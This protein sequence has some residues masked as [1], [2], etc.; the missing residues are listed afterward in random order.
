M[1]SRPDTP[2]DDHEPGD[3]VLAILRVVT[4]SLGAPL[5]FIALLF[6]VTGT[7]GETLALGAIAA[8]V[9]AVAA[10]PHPRPASDVPPARAGQHGG[11]TRPAPER[12]A[13]G[14]RRPG[15]ALD[16]GGRQEACPSRHERPDLGADRRGA[17]PD[18]CGGPH[19]PAR[20][21]QPAGPPAAGG[22]RRVVTRFPSPEAPFHGSRP[23]GHDT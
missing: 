6:A 7:S 12:T 1:N 14:F 13:D 4:L 8:A 9:L 11:S 21:A 19:A 3:P 5:T 16:A 22:G 17:R 10:R 20:P 15:A 18:P 23:A 2:D